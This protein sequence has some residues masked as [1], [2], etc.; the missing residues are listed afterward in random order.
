M[1]R[2]TG[3]ILA[4]AISWLLVGCAGDFKYT[5]PASKPTL[6]NS[7]LVKKSKD[8]VWKEIVPALGRKFFVINNLDRDSGIINISY[9]G[10][11]ERY[12]DCGRIC[13]YVKNLR[14]ERVYDFPASKGYAE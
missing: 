8:E 1:K 3:C 9:T 6:S 13:S 11:P 4:A 2:F 14:G 10:D 12:V 7:V 5:R